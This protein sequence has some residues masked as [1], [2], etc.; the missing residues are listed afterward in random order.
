M[1]NSNK[2]ALLKAVEEVLLKAR[3]KFTSGTEEEWNTANP[4]LLKGEIG[5]VAGTYPAKYKIGD[6]SKNWTSLSWGHVTALSQLTEDA[7]HRLTTDTEKKYWNEKAD[8]FHFD[9][10]LYKASATA[11]AQKQI[12][13]DI[14]AKAQTTDNFIV[15]TYNIPFEAD[16]Y[17]TSGPVSGLFVINEVLPDRVTGVVS[18]VAMASQTDFNTVELG[19]TFIGFEADGSV[20]F[21]AMPYT[22]E[23]VTPDGLPAYEI[24]KGSTESGFAATYYLTKNGEKVGVSINIPLDQVLKSSSIKEVVTADKPYTGAKVGDKYIEFLFQNN[25]TPQYLPVQDLVDIYTGDNTYIQVLGTNVIQ[26]KYDALKTKLFSD[27]GSVFDPKGAGTA[28]AQQ[29][30]KDFANSSF[31]IQC[32]IPGME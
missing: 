1:A 24:K 14:V 26:L 19:T 25:N 30:I 18:I 3:I 6:G 4:V 32:S 29:A 9:Y 17:E 31:V 16:D 28:A 27:A 8:V 15:Y 10:E 11:A 12:V 13:K 7:T 20:D 22:R 23:L 21:T 2:K 5:L